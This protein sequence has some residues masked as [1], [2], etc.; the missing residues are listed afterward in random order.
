MIPKIIHYC[1]LSDDPFPASIQYCIN[2]WKKYLPDYELMLWDF[3]RFPKGKSQWVDEAF[4]A[5]KYAFA[6]DYIR[7]YALYYYGGIY[8]DSDVEVVRSYNDLLHLPYFIGMENTPSG[9]EAATLGFEKGHKLIGNLLKYY[10]G[11]RFYKK[12]GTFDTKPLPYIIRE[13]IDKDFTYKPIRDISEYDNNPDIINVFPVD[14]FSPKSWDTKEILFT[15]NTFSIHHFEGSWLDENQE[16]PSHKDSDGLSPFFSIL[17]PVY[18]TSQY[19]DRCMNS[20]TKQTF[21]NIEII[22]VDDGSTDRS[23]EMCDRWEKIDA[24]VKVIH[25]ENKG[26]FM[27]RKVAVAIAKGDYHVFV[28]SDDWIDTNLCQDVSNAIQK[29]QPDADI[30]HFGTYIEKQGIVD[31]STKKSFENSFNRFVECKTTKEI[32]EEAFIKRSFAWNMW[33]KAYKKDIV[34][35]AYSMMPDIRCTYAEDL[36]TS[37]L[38]YSITNNIIPLRKR[39]YHYSIGC[40][41]S[42]A[43]DTSLRPF[44]NMLQAYDVFETLKTVSKQKELEFKSSVHCIDQLRNVLHESVQSNLTATSE[45]LRDEKI[46]LWIERIGGQEAVR[47][48]LKPFVPC[49]NN[50]VDDYEDDIMERELKRFQ[51]KNQKHLK[52]LRITIIALAVSLIINILLIVFSLVVG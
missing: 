26:L 40:G 31:K 28:D 2:S 30:I 1:W 24:R 20:V 9:I 37:Y 3:N 22:L 43:S 15:E 51:K 49:V 10:E 4:D 52:S 8:L 5:H 29:S 21:H 35:K 25:Q 19:L 18:N 48:L 7:L 47:S 34:R 44:I 14:T 42:T 41:M 33:G 27:A 38:L 11:K 12:D 46:T 39:L 45:A 36:F 6:A 13:E 16:A 32:M 17:V 50:E 23:G